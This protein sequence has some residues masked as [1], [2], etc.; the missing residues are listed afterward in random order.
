[1]DQ[2]IYNY[3]PQTGELVSA[4]AADPSPL[5]PGIYLLPAYAT[6]TPPPAAGVREVALFRS[7]DGG[8]PAD[9]AFGTW[10]LL[11]DWRG[12]ALYA[13]A[14]GLSAAIDMPGV[15]PSDVGA[16]ETPSPDQDCIWDGSGWVLDAT[17]KAQRVAALRT[18]TL[19]RINAACNAALAALTASYPER[20]IS[21][22]PQ[23]ER[24]ARALTANL[25]AATPLLVAIA[26]ARGFD[27]A[28]LAER[29]CTKADNYAVIS[30]QLIGRRQALEDAL[31]AI[32]PS[33]A[34]AEARL[35]A[36]NWETM[37]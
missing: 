13:T 10:Q 35:N 19:E 28:V 9:H 17:R 8:V 18:A 21:S 3:C 20:E 30:G 25:A 2:T 24:E 22:W 36:I 34:D 14:D 33:S 32:D 26:A 4:A 27:V 15:T 23:Q 29:V 5:E 11:P 37:P 7:A 6:P 1:M 31:M 12:V 16:T